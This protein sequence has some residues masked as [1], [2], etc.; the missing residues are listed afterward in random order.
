MILIEN[1]F[2]DDTVMR[3]DSYGWQT[4]EVDGHNLEE[5]DQAIIA[6]K[7]ETEKPTMISVEQQLVLAPQ[8]NLEHQMFMVPLSAKKKL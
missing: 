1:W 6:A 8:I 7:H 2:T 5:I 4:I 3:F